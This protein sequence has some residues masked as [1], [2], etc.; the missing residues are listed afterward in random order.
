MMKKQYVYAALIFSIDM[1]H[2]HASWT[3]RIE[4]N[5]HHGHAA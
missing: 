3:G 4:M 2:G 5:M 1:Q